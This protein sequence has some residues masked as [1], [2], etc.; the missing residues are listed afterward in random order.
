[1]VRLRSGWVL[2]RFNIVRVVYLGRNSEKEKQCLTLQQRIR[3]H[4]AI[5]FYDNGEE[6]KWQ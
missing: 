2:M 4:E 3:P 5:D 6:G 1:M